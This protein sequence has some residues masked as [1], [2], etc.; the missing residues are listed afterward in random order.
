M[1]GGRLPTISATDPNAAYANMVDD[2][3]LQVTRDFRPTWTRQ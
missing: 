3:V 1:S 2:M